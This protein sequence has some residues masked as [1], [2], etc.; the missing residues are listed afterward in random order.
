MS[1]LSSHSTSPCTNLP[2]A[3]KNL[4]PNNTIKALIASADYKDDDN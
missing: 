2:L 1:W 3:N 4:V